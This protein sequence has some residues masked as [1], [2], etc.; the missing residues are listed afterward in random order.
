[1]FQM[2]LDQGKEGLGEQT[3]CAKERHAS[4]GSL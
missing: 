3:K 2:W 1:V 4:V